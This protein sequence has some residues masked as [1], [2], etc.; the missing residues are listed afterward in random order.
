MTK[1]HIYLNT[2]SRWSWNWPAKSAALASGALPSHGKWTRPRSKVSECVNPQGMDQPRRPPSFSR[3]SLKCRAWRGWC[4]EESARRRSR[5]LSPNGSRGRKRVAF[6]AKPTDSPFTNL[7]LG[8]AH[9]STEV[10]RLLRPARSNACA[11]DCLITPSTITKAIKLAMRQRCWC[12]NPQNCSEAAPIKWSKP[13]PPR[14]ENPRPV[15]ILPGIG[16]AA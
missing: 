2:P 12:W 3:R 14:G 7:Q 8:V 10:Q 11:P 6:S 4:C 13:R 16:R 5:P 15:E 9:P 1:L